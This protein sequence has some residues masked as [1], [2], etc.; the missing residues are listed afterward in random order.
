[1]DGKE[2]TKE[3]KNLSEQNMQPII[4]YV[5]P[6]DTSK[7]IGVSYNEAFKGLNEQDYVCFVDGDTIFLDSHFGL[8]IKQIIKEHG[9]N[10]A[11]CMTN[12]VGC[13]WQVFSRINWFNENMLD[14]DR[15]TKECWEQFNTQVEDVTD[16]QL[17]SGVMILLKKETWLKM[18]KFKES[19]ML[20]IDNDFHQKLK[21]CGEKLWLMKGIY[22][23]HKYRFGD[24]TDKK[25][26]L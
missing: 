20:G 24:M 9:I 1:M 4:R 18:G 7:N 10:A 25:H 2:T 17:M 3:Q 6:F 13:S 15:M 11:T 14:H 5:I 26:L 23:Y 16:N 22:L 12:R 19:G 8:K 21:D